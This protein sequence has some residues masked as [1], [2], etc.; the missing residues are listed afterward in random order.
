ML[1]IE[2][3]GTLFLG[4]RATSSA[5]RVHGSV[6][7]A[8]RDHI[9]DHDVEQYSLDK[10]PSS[11]S[12][13][14]E[15]HLLVCEY[16]RARLL[17][18]EPV[19][20]VHFTDHGPVYSRITTLTTGEMMARHWGDELDLGKVFRN[21]SDAEQYLNTSFSQMFPKHTC[22]GRCGPTQN[23]G[24]AIAPPTRQVPNKHSGDDADPDKKAQAR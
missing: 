11:N 3:N 6:Q 10:L 24:L 20:Y 8:M 16:C 15:E 9:P 1:L 7:T 13:I 19:N 14:I 23:W 18:I 2:Q 5:R 22:D 17:G 4:E 12:V 21:M